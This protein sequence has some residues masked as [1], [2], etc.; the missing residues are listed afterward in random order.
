MRTD[1][2]KLPARKK[3][4]FFPFLT[5]EGLCLRPLALR[6][7]VGSPGCLTVAAEPWRLSPTPSYNLENPSRS[8]RAALPENDGAR[9]PGFPPRLTRWIGHRS[10]PASAIAMSRSCLTSE[11]SRSSVSLS[12]RERARA[13]TRGE[14]ARDLRCVARAQVLQEKSGTRTASSAIIDHGRVEDDDV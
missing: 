5:S 7:P 1:G 6:G 10:S 9:S 11:D 8:G 12:D 13:R 4:F 2:L 3:G 14:A